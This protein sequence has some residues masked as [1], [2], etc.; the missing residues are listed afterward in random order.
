[1][2][3][4][5]RHTFWPMLALGIFVIAPALPAQ[6][7]TAP[8]PG[9][10]TASNKTPPL[11]VA[12]SPVDLFSELLAMTPADRDRQLASRPPEIRKRIIAKLAE[13]EAMKPEDRALRLR[14][15]QL[16]WYFLQFIQ[17]PQSSRSSFL[18][19]VP[20]ASRQ[21]VSDHLQQWDRLPADEQ[22]E[23]LKYE[24]TMERL[25]GQH[26][27]AATATNTI[28]ASV[29]AAA[30][31]NALK[32]LDNFLQLSPERRQQ[33]YANFQRF[34]ELT[35]DERQKTI[36]TLPANQRQQIA[37]ALQMLSRL[38]PADRIEYLKGLKKFSSMTDAEREDFL[39]NARRWQAVPSAER[40]A[41]RTLVNGLPPTP[42][43]PPGL[44]SP[45]LPVRAP[46]QV[47]LPVPA[48]SAP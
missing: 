22:K 6:T 7:P 24:Q 26:L 15:T 45:P 1:M 21:L 14:V 12:K 37:A 5:L 42:P 13:Y 34:F 33:M 48:N 25:A 27:D 8:N 18:A 4:L 3:A 38:P 41:W 29:P 2:N 40:Q 31:E 44:A 32:N 39:K 20:E 23:V 43:L 19:S 35:D 30:R 10:A 17:M 11:P 46:L 36:G 16:R 47:S 28:I 9:P